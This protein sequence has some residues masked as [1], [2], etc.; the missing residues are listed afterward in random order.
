VP[1]MPKMPKKLSAGE[2]VAKS[3][4]ASP[5]IFWRQ[6]LDRIAPWGELL[7]TAAAADTAS[8]CVTDGLVR[9]V[10]TIRAIG[11]PVFH[12][13]IG[14]LDSKG[15]GKMVERDVPVLCGRARATGR[16]RVRRR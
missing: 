5:S 3:C 12:G 2:R 13:G 11:F 10:R 15:R 4:S 1:K 14:P 9:D 16:L 7:S 6:T 8:G